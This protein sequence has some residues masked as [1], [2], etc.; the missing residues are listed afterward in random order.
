MILMGDENGRS[1]K[2]NNNAYCQDNAARLDGLEPGAARGGAASPS[3]PG[4]CR[5]RS[6]LPLLAAPHWLRGDPVAAGGLPAVRWL[7]PDGVPMSEAEWTNGKVK[8]MAVAF[9]GAA[10]EGRCVLTNAAAEDVPFRLPEVGSRRQWRLRLD[11]GD[12]RIDPEEAPLAAGRGVYGAGT[13]PSALFRL[14]GGSRRADPSAERPPRGRPAGDLMP[15]E[16]RDGRI[17]CQPNTTRSRGGPGLVARRASR[18]RWRPSSTPGA[19]R[20]GRRGRSSR[21]APRRRWRARS[22]AAASRARWWPRRW[23]RSA[24]GRPRMLDYGVSDAE[25]FAVGLA[26]GGRIRVMVEPVGVGEGPSAE[27]LERLVGGAG[28]AGAGRLCGAPRGV[29]AAA[30]RRARRSA[31]AGGRGGDDRGPLGVRGRL[32]PR[33]AQPAAPAWRWSAGCISRRRWCRWRGS[34]ATTRR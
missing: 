20:R 30:G 13:E 10:G 18:W 17:G 24:D 2:G 21:S 32:V 22:R 34:P 4:R 12:G 16:R 3:S 9:A 28:G 6:E 1:Q 19:R 29:G 25:A 15:G 14:T 7:R 5:L 27:L 26:C 8:A 33:G 11:S 23:P 31:L